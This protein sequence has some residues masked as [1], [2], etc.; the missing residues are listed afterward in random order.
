M[1]APVAAAEPP[2]LKGSVSL[3]LAI[4]IQS[5]GIALPG[6]PTQGAQSL[7]LAGHIRARDELYLRD[8]FFRQ[9]RGVRYASLR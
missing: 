5:P 3:T 2:S 1:A 9:L 6:R 7:S 8:T 4:V